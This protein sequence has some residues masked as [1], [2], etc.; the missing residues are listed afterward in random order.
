MLYPKS[1][2]VATPPNIADGRKQA[3][4][5]HNKWSS[6]IFEQVMDSAGGNSWT[7][8]KIERTENGLPIVDGPPQNYTP[9]LRPAT[10][11][12]AVLP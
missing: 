5:I 6:G 8:W 12:A 3:F 9:T 11:A 1:H 2:F 4:D 10:G 7:R